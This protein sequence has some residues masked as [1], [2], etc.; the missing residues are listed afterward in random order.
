[1]LHWLGDREHKFKIILGTRSLQN[2]KKFLKCQ[3]KE[4]G[5]FEVK[6]GSTLA[7][8]ENK[9]GRNSSA[10]RFSQITRDLVPCILEQNIY[11]KGHTSSQILFHDHKRVH[12]KRNQTQ[13]GTENLIYK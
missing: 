6:K 4:L 10:N 5:N 9:L 3:S 1:M 11:N 8:T 13:T 2:T 7:S 12:T